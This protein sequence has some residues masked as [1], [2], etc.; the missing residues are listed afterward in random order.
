MHRFRKRSDAK[1]AP[2]PDPLRA[3]QL[4]PLPSLPPAEDFRTSLIL[5]DLTRRF[6]VLRSSSGNPIRLDDLK[7]KFAEQRARGSEKQVSEEEEDMILEALSRLRA[8]SAH[9]RPRADSATSRSQD[10]RPDRSPT[11]PPSPGLAPSELTPTSVLHTSPSMTSL[12]STKGSHSNRRMSNN[13]FGSGKLRDQSYLRSVQQTRRTTGSTRTYSVTPSESNMSISSGMT[14][15][16]RGQNA[17]IYSDNQ[18]LRPVTPDG[19]SSVPSSSA[20]SSPNNDRKFEREQTE[21]PTSRTP[22]TEDEP[23]TAPLNTRISK[24]LLPQGLHR[25]SMALDE[26]IRELEEEGDDEILMERSPILHTPIPSSVLSANFNMEPVPAGDYEAGTAVST[27]T[28]I[29]SGDAQRGSPFPRS[30]T[31]S[32]T[33]RLPGYTPGMPRPMTPRD[34]TFDSDD[35]TPSSTPRAT[36]P[37]LPGT[38]TPVSAAIAQQFTSGLYRSSS[39]ASTTRQAARPVSPPYLSTSP[40]FFN[41]S[42][43]GRYTPEDRPRAGS[44]GQA[45]DTAE[46]PTSRRLP[47]SPLSGPAFQPLTNPPSR[48]T[49]PSNITWNTSPSTT[50]RHGRSGSS[51]SGHSR[52]AS[53]VSLHD[54]NGDA[55][56]RSKSMSRS[57]RSPALP[58][59]PWMER[60]QLDRG[61]SPAIDRPPSAMSGRDASSPV[62]MLNRPLRSPTPTYGLSRS[63]TTP[64]FSEQPHTNGDSFGPSRRSSKQSVPAHMS[65]N[66]SHASGLLLAPIANSS[67]SSLDSMGSSY[68]S[69]DEDHTKNRLFGLLS[70]LDSEQTEWHDV[71]KSSTSTPG[72]SPY[73]GLDY[74]DAVR[75]QSGL[76]KSDFVAI[77]DKLVSAALAKAA[78]PEGRN[79]A[80]SIRKRRPSTS[81]SNYSVNGT[82]E[83]RVTSPTPQP[84]PQSQPVASSS[85]AVDND[86]IAKANALL[87]SVVDSINSPRA[88]VAQLPAPTT[89]PS[90]SSSANQS[91]T[92]NELSSPGR[93]HR[94]LADVLFGGEDPFSTDLSPHV[95]VSQENETPRAQ[96]LPLTVTEAQPLPEP[97]QSPV[98]M[99]TPRTQELSL[100]ASP[101]LTPSISTSLSLDPRSLALDV[102]R[103]A[104]AATAA[105][106]KSPSIP[107]FAEANGATPR[108]KISPNQ[109]SSPKL[110]SA[111]T[112][113]D[114][115][116]LRPTTPGGST[117]QAP[118]ARIG[119]R[120][121]KLRGTLKTKPPTLNGDE[122]TPFPFELRTPPSSQ[123]ANYSTANLSLR[124]EPALHSA[125]DGGRLKAPVPPMPSPPA[126]AAPGLKGFMA[127]FRKQKTVDTSYQ[128]PI[129]GSASFVTSASSSSQFPSSSSYSPSSLPSISTREHG[130]EQS[131]SAPA[132]RLDFMANGTDPKQMLPPISPGL[133]ESESTPVQ[134]HNDEAAL[135][136]LF[137]AAS[138]LGLDQAALSDLLARSPSTSSRSTAW[139]KVT[140]MT[141]VS[142]KRRSALRNAHESSI[143][144]RTRSP[145]PSEGRTSMDA[146][147][148]RPST[149]APPPQMSAALPRPRPARAGENPGSSIVRRTIIVPSDTRTSTF[150]LAA[151]MRKQSTSKRR[152]STS[153]T[154]TH[155][156]GSVQERVPT[157]PPQRTSTS[158]RFSTDTS[159]PV[160]R[161]P[162]SIAAR[163]EHLAVPAQTENSSSTYDSLYE[164]YSGDG[165]A[166]GPSNLEAQNG[167]DESHEG[168]GP[169]IELVELANGETIWSIVNGLRDTDGAESFYGDR[170]SFI[171]E[172]SLKDNNEGV[173]V[174][175]KGHER[176]SSRGS[177]SSF[178][179]RKKQPAKVNRPETKVFFSS[180]A[181][182]GRLIENLSRG[183]DAGSFNI[184]PELP[185]SRPHHQVQHST[186]SSIGSSAQMSWTVEERL[187]HMLGSM[188]SDP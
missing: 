25:A 186:S 102:Q 10:E 33:P 157:P 31:T 12:S 56:E 72:T 29:V 80:S 110:V 167:Q 173:K 1:R 86:H 4:E 171:S 179:S 42:T 78:T 13:L 150:D 90:S 32:P 169:A 125:A 21:T 174:F 51:V 136:Q 161:L 104:E 141:S 47:A 145:Q 170:A 76:T 121:R 153:A 38:T 152:R 158:R 74:E 44:V 3:P 94:A 107:K 27:D 63:P 77:Q 182:I 41:R 65:F 155:S 175:F 92:G 16:R 60:E 22:H 180:S 58:D 95:F 17:S 146:Y 53:S 48:P 61:K 135:R 101:G 134:T 88:Q 55:L 49:T 100:P 98:T 19:S 15:S 73:E 89:V 106:R 183:V 26:V 142:E 132:T 156:K 119:S 71:S 117:H 87:D 111:S 11:I 83:Q 133:S 54:I 184:T 108:K 20:P 165:K 143:F 162:P 185:Q 14:S 112:S 96:E 79:R 7:L 139:T 28:A 57:L 99:Q 122:I 149:E 30:R 114:T 40:L 115:I 62:Q 5:P 116:P 188:G 181:Q 127:R 178:L 91:P 140:R 113:V 67:R 2:P 124:G 69:W 147:S 144:D 9:T 128:R 8:E 177:T 166:A 130:S 109:I 103:R 45:S 50:S 64:T 105:L 131:Y 43:N 82:V 151:L 160:P 37:R 81:Q 159:P 34:A 6:S 148:P 172:Y 97:E 68:H 118:S 164:M 168:S 52:S 176:K 59:S 120:F 66:S 154:S 93:R 23:E 39:N 129:P 75:R 84:Q 35:L 138:N 18:S 36:S 126:S 187:E 137:D 85:R 46:S 70:S 24:A 163:V 123:E